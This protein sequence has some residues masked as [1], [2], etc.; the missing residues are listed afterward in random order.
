MQNDNMG[1]TEHHTHTSTKGEPIQQL[2]KCTRTNKGH[3]DSHLKTIVV[4]LL[5]SGTASFQ[6]LS[7]QSDIDNLFVP[8]IS[9]SHKTILS[10]TSSTKLTMSIEAIVQGLHTQLA[11][12][13]YETSNLSSQNSSTTASFMHKWIALWWLSHYCS[14]GLWCL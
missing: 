13:D 12:W 6:T 1:K 7:T 9:E 11:E 5:S 10:S 14:N 3:G 8:T 4:F 2:L